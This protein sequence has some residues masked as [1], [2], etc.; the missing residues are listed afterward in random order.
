MIPE[1]VLLFIVG[2]T[3]LVATK[4]ITD[5]V[6]PKLGAILATVPVGLFSA[7]FI[8]TE[9]KLPHYLDS[10]IKQT[11][12]I[13]ATSIFYLFL[14]KKNIIKHRTIYLLCVMIWVIYVM[15]QLHW[16]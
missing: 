9:D 14:L 7:Y 2:G 4:H 1:Y 6:S 5:N 10:Y 13:V 15:I 3:L 12:F 16:V 8:M 11:A